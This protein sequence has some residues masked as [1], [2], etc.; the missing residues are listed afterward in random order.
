MRNEAASARLRT[1]L[2]RRAEETAYADASPSLKRIVPLF[3]RPGD[4]ELFRLEHPTVTTS[5]TGIVNASVGDVRMA[6][7]NRRMYRSPS[8]SIREQT[9]TNENIDFGLCVHD[10]LDMITRA[11]P[12]CEWAR[13]F[14]RI[15]NDMNADEVQRMSVEYPFVIYMFNGWQLAYRGCV[16]WYNSIVD[17][18]TRWLHILAVDGRDSPAVPFAAAFRASI[19]AELMRFVVHA[20]EP[21]VAAGVVRGAPA[22]IV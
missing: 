22:F 18:F 15:D 3:T 19:Y 20:Q 9:G 14:G 11:S 17:A 16:Y 7:F 8:V 12:G 2:V 21:V 6:D 4:R 1:W 10:F 13:Y 5:D